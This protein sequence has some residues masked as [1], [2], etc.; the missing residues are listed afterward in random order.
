MIEKANSERA[1]LKLLATSSVKQRQ[2]AA[3]ICY[4]CYAVLDVA[5]LHNVTARLLPLHRRSVRSE[6]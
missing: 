6:P 1:V 2:I 3:A 5:E 4:E